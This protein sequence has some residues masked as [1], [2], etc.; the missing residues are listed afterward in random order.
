[1]INIDISNSNKTR[2]RKGEMSIMKA[3]TI[4][5]MFSLIGLTAQA[6][7]IPENSN[8]LTDW[9][10]K[11][12][13]KD[14][15][16]SECRQ[17]VSKM[18]HCRFSLT[19]ETPLNALVAINTEPNNLFKWMEGAK[20]TEQI[21]PSPS[22]IDY[23]VFTE[24]TFPWPLSNRYAVTRTKVTKDPAT[25]AVTV[26]FK[27]PSHEAMPG[28]RKDLV[29]KYEENKKDFTKFSYIKGSWV[30]TKQASGKTLVSYESI[31][32]PAGNIESFIEGADGLVNKTMA[33]IF[34]DGAY[35]ASLKTIR[36]MLE[37]SKEPQY[38]N[39]V[40]DFI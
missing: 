20:V 12:K 5:I 27:T 11:E 19:T 21:A 9:E 16:K 6:S 14:G 39:A 34:T 4:L 30:F 22:R 18:F 28:L 32:L 15:I 40:I 2:A 13:T 7:T 17:H 37:M 8:Y 3:V 23:H 29:I 26:S 35:E 38:I 1:M 10:F 24:F 36:N 25:N 33:D 31:G